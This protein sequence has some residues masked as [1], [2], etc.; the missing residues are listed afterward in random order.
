MSR[1]DIAIGFCFG[2]FTVLAVNTFRHANNVEMYRPSIVN[3]SDI[4]VAT[5]HGDYTRTWW[6]LEDRGYN[7]KN[8]QD[9]ASIVNKKLEGDGL[10][11]LPWWQCR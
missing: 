8:C 6:P 7:W 11:H 1:K 9:M 10:K 3:F 5:F 4:K 2:V